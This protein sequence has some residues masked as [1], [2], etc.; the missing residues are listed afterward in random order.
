MEKSIADFVRR[1]HLPA[2]HW[3]YPMYEDSTREL[4]MFSVAYGGACDIYSTR[5]GVRY[6]SR[7]GWI[8]LDDAC[9]PMSTIDSM[10]HDVP[11]FRLRPSDS[12]LFSDSL[13]TR[14]KNGSRADEFW[15]LFLIKN[16][17]T[18]FDVIVREVRVDPHRFALVA[19]QNPVVALS[20]TIPFNARLKMA[21][22]EDTL[23]G[24]MV[25]LPSVRD[26]PE[27]L[28][29][30][31]DLPLYRTGEGL[32][33]S[34]VY[35]R[36]RELLPSLIARVQTLSERAA[37][38]VY[39]VE[40][41]SVSSDSLRSALLHALTPKQR[42]VP[43]ALAATGSWN[44]RRADSIFARET[45]EHMGTHS[46]REMRNAILRVRKN[47][48]PGSLPTFI[49]SDVVHAPWSILDL[50][51]HLD[52]RFRPA[53]NVAALKL[54]SAP[55]TPDSVI[56]VLTDGLS[57]HR[58]PALAQRLRERPHADTSRALL[59][60]LSDLESIMDGK[61]AIDAR[62]KLAKL[63]QANP[64]S[65]AEPHE[66]SPLAAIPVDTNT[67]AQDAWMSTEQCR[68]PDDWSEQLRNNIGHGARLLTG[69]LFCNRAAAALDSAFELP[70]ANDSVYV[71]GVGHDYVMAFPPSRANAEVTLV[72]FD[73]SFVER[74]R[75][76]IR[77]H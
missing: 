73:S 19:L 77:V 59:R 48:L 3:I 58:D 45:L 4:M 74:S 39:M 37:L 16:V 55:S 7:V 72:R 60:A 38:R 30:I 22:L 47:E 44:S 35:M 27:R 11:W 13:A 20:D 61:A 31:T 14:L 10:Q 69:H 26:D 51:S 17:A 54:A 15:H 42:R 18:P 33:A 57:R 71:F 76:V 8:E 34:K 68:T 67:H 65:V 2:V 29:Q 36:M 52:E 28:T 53:R 40:E 75:C 70:A 41:L 32:A 50:I 56:S 64:S 46:E 43:L 5:T 23:A 24:T 62:E 12:Y 25:Q 1:A 6:G 49:M 9:L 63:E 66:T 21:A